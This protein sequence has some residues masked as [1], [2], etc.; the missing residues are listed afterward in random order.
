MGGF[1]SVLRRSAAG[2]L[3]LAICLLPHA[4]AAEKRLA[5][6]IG[7]GGYTSDRLPNAP[8]DAEMMATVL[9]EVGFE[10]R[11]FSDLSFSKMR[12]EV[13]AFGKRLSE[14]KG[15]GLFYYAGHAIQLEDQNY[16][17]PLKASIDSKADVEDEAFALRRVI[18]QMKY[19]DNSTNIIILDACRNNPFRGFF[20]GPA[21]RGLS[22]LVAPRNMFVAYAT[23]P[24]DVA[25]D[26]SGR[27]SLYTHTVADVIRAGNMSIQDSFMQVAKVVDEKTKGTQV[28]WFQ[29][30]LT[31]SFTFWVR[32]PEPFDVSQLDGR[33]RSTVLQARQEAERA[34]A[35]KGQVQQAARQGKA[36][37]DHAKAGRSGYR[38]FSYQN[39]DRFEGQWAR[40]KPH[41][42]GIYSSA[43]GQKR[44]LGKFDSG[45]MTFGAL[46]R[47]TPQ[48]PFAYSYQGQF[49]NNRPHG[50]GVLLYQGP[51]Y[52]QIYRGQFQNGKQD[53]FGVGG[54]VGGQ[55]Y[56]GAWRN[57]QQSG[58]GVIWSADGQHLRSQVQINLR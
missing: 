27:N 54:I 11:S 30:S 52:P 20:R 42:Y 37:S 35:L 34:D 23:A 22:G 26:G 45:E 55:K 25:P 2:L 14:E 31:Q 21:L 12:D 13:K 10:V 56:E 44:F 47:P 48:N 43:D 29:S 49:Q 19:A 15:V 41:G 46:L 6:V 1:M 18:N 17:I 53:G 24:G 16:L 5:L 4:A 57:G 38:V 36:A 7:N 50:L 58:L 51:R 8:R 33:A 39:G 32:P 3:A 40:D 28:P 9:R